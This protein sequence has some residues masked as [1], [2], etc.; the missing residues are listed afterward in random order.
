MKRVK[1]ETYLCCATL[2]LASSPSW[3]AT[4]GS[5]G[6]TSSGNFALTLTAPPVP[7]NVQVLDLQALACRTPLAKGPRS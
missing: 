4:Q 5:L 6:S 1:L 2:L 7:R 3:A